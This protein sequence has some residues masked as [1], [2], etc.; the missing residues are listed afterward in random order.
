MAAVL[1]RHAAVVAHH[2]GVE[3]AELDRE[4]DDAGWHAPYVGCSNGR[5]RQRNSYYVTGWL[6]E[7]DPGS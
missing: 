5:T 4:R 7:V 1:S 2:V 6:A 3:G